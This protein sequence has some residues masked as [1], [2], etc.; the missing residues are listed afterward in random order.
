MKAARLY[1]KNDIRIEEV[2]KPLINENELLLR[3]EA[4]FICGTDVRM[5][6]NGH[7]TSSENSPLIIGHELS[8]VIEEVGC[9]ID[10]YKKNMRVAVAP[11]MGCGVCDLCVSGNTHLCSDYKALGINLDGGFAE[12][13]K[14]PEAA[15]RQGNVFEIGSNVSYEEAALAEPLSCVYNGFERSEISPGDVVL[16]IGAGPI[17]IIHAKL[18]K[19]AGGRVIIH[20]L[21]QERLDVCHQVDSDFQT[22]LDDATLCN[23]ILDMTNGKGVD[24]CITACPSVSAQEKSL[25]LM[26]V[27]GRVLFF[28]GLPKGAKACLD[29]NLIHY[30]QLKVTG[31]TRAS[32][33]QFR[34]TLDLIE[35]GLIEVKDLISSRFSIEDFVK[36]VEKASNADG[37]KNVI[38]FQERSSTVDSAPKKS[39]HL[40]ES[41][42]TSSNRPTPVKVL[43]DCK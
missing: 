31:T 3:T 14:I 32:L 12:Y 30:R 15:V 17:G 2:K 35:K 42:S 25:E 19:M 33:I 11:N 28:G 37:L 21:V 5:F 13:V 16:I 38:I 40:I 9:N 18:A 41:I 1:G 20:D 24:V 36:A 43:S 27:N 29:T 7:G 4:S 26:A 39:K 6:K 22:I 23:T 10:S 34:R 8:G